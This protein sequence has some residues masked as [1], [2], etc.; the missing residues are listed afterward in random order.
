MINHIFQIND[1]AYTLNL[2]LAESFIKLSKH[3]NNTGINPR[4]IVIEYYPELTKYF[5]NLFKS[6]D[7]NDYLIINKSELSKIKI[8]HKNEP[9]LLHGPTYYLIAKLIYL[10]FKNL[11]WV[12]WGKGSKINTKNIKSVIFTPIK[13]IL[14]HNFKSIVTLMDGDKLSLENDYKLNNIRTIPYYS[15]RSEAFTKHI[16]QLIKDYILPTKPIVVLGNSGHCIDDY[17][18]MIDELQG[19]K[20]KVELHCMI[21]YGADNVGEKLEILNIKGKSIFKDDFFIDD[22]YLEY[23]DYLDYMNKG[24]V[25]IGASVDQSGLGAIYNMLLLGKRVFI[26]GKNYN[27]TKQLNL[28]VNHIDEINEYIF[29]PLSD[30]EKKHNYRIISNMGASNLQSWIDYLK[31]ITY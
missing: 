22:K 4:I 9:L 18:H 6:F 17:I 27:H 11:N 15:E 25:Y 20:G 26:N 12:C 13:Y 30:E 7:F 28:Y 19:L 16:D 10:G 1:K 2:I 29:T 5:I 31:C 21:S 23:F 24:T 3:C 14:Y 8:I